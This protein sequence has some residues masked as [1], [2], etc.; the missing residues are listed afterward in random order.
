MA[1]KANIISAAVVYQIPEM[2]D[3]LLIVCQ[4]N[5]DMLHV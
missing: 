4:S 3:L 5:F 2:G 1:N